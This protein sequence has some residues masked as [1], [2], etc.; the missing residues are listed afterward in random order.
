MGYDTQFS[1]ELTITPA[2]S[3]E[4]I[5]YLN[6][7]HSTRRMFR[8]VHILKATYQGKH[9]ILG[10]SDYGPE[11]CYFAKDDWYMWQNP[12]GSV[13]DNNRSTTG[14]S[15]W[16]PW[17]VN[18]QWELECEPGSAYEFQEWLAFMIAHFFTPW[19]RYLNGKVRWRGEEFDDMGT[20]L[21]KDNN[22]IIN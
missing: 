3:D 11:G 20:I 4:Q 10:T 7:F 18:K 1:G 15:L 9:G 12:D 8:D 6:L 21:V 2:L 22:I 5:E 17:Y 16:C 14:L 13:P 19:G